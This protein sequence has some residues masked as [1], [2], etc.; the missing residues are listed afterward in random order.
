MVKRLTAI[1]QASSVALALG[2]SIGTAQDFNIGMDAAQKG[3][4]VTAMQQWQPLLEAGDAK[5]QV[6]V[7]LMYEHAHGVPQDH[8]TAYMGYGIAAINGSGVAS[9]LRDQ[10]SQYMTAADIAE[11]R[12]RARVCMASVYKDCD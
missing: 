2:P 1:A 10:L 6:N 9:N 8:V 11:A 5:A 4:F 3:D 7:G 12:R